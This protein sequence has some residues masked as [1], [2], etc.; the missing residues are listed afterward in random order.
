[1]SKIVYLLCCLMLLA[2]PAQAK[3]K[4]NSEKHRELPP[5]LQKKV[6][7]GRDLPPGWQKKLKPGERLE[8]SLYL[9]LEAVPAEVITLL[10]PPAPGVSFK[11]LEDK[12]IKLNDLNR[13][14][15]EVLEIEHLPVPKLPRLPKPPLP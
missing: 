2:V 3:K 4:Y 9:R 12:I 7:R 5:G 11:K 1:M 13:Q 6:D 15:L 14:V 8:E 10:P